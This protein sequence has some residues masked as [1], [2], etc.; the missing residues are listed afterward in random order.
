MTGSAK[1]AVTSTE[2]YQ[3]A[4]LDHNKSPRCYGELT[5]A[6]HSARGHN[7][8]CGDVVHIELILKDEQVGKLQ[9]TAQSC[10]LCK[11]SASIMCE[12]LQNHSRVQILDEVNAFLQMLRI[13]D[14]KINVNISQSAAIF[15]VVRD[16]PARAKCVMLPWK[17]LFGALTVK[18]STKSEAELVVSTEA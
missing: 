3:R 12:S 11:A 14:E 9:F 1:A 4:V 6:T 17:T 7:P 15:S 18:D 10:A 16:F 2:L 13:K 8:I 5:G